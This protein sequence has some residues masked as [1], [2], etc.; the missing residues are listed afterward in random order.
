LKPHVITVASKFN[1]QL[2]YSYVK[3]LNNVRY[4]DSTCLYD[5]SELTIG[6]NNAELILK[7][8]IE[9]C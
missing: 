9:I 4:V 7:R 3:K 6:S 8:F 2:C 1:H 5:F